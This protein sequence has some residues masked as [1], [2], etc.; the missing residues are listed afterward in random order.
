MIAKRCGITTM[1]GAGLA[2]HGTALF[3]GV[4]LSYKISIPISVLTGVLMGVAAYA[5]Q[6][7]ER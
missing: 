6:G 2:L 3:Q 7:Q 1:V 5:Y 4:E